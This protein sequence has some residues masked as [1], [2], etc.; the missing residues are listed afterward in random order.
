VVSVAVGYTSGRLGSP[1]AHDLGT[2][3][4]YAQVGVVPCAAERGTCSAEEASGFGDHLAVG[5]FRA[6]GAG[7]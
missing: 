7:N 3:C 5:C 6:S 1:V 2:G 4:A